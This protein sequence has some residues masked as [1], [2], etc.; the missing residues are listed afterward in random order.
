MLKTL[1]LAA[2]LAAPEP[3]AEPQKGWVVELHGYTHHAQAK[4][5]PWVVELP[6]YTYHQQAKPKGW[7]REPVFPKE[8]QRRQLRPV[9]E[10]VVHPIYV[11]DLFAFVKQLKTQK[12][13]EAVEGL[14]VDDLPAFSMKLKKR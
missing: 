3:Q 10:E 4:P 9:R 1:M 5:K 11:D 7:I 8:M 13:G 2:L 6:G 12:Q 14:Y